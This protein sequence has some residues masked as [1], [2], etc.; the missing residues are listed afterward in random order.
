ML[1]A[2][3]MLAGCAQLRMIGVQ[4][5]LISV[6]ENLDKPAAEPPVLAAFGADPPVTTSQDW[7]Q[8]RAPLLRA[9]F[10]EHV[11]G[12]MPGPAPVTAVS[13][14][15]LSRDAYGG[16]A[17]V[18]ELTLRIGAAD[19]DS[20]WI[21]RLALVL[22]RKALDAG[23]SSPVIIAQNFCGN[24]VAVPGFGVAAPLTAY[25]EACESAFW[26]PIIALLFGAHN[27]RP[28]VEQIIARG[29]AYVS[30]YPGEIVP[31][32]RAAAEPALSKLAQLG[33][34]YGRPGAV[35]AWAWAYLRAA[36]Y[37]VTRDEIAADKI[38][39]WGHSRNG[40]SA[41]LAGVFDPRIAAVIA[42]QSGTGGATLNRNPAGETVAQITDG[43]GYWFGEAYADYA[44]RED[45]LPI[46]QHQLLA[47]LAPRPVFL[48]NAR[49][50]V[51]SGP[52]SSFRAA[53]G[54]QDAY[55]L[56]GAQGLRQIAMDPPDLN[57]DMAFFLRAGG[58]GVNSA[59][60][61]AFLAFL[62][63]H[64]PPDPAAIT[65]EKRAQDAQAG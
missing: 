4:T 58:H 43:Y 34:A 30:Q 8:R 7:T 65:R 45:A 62:D 2:A 13:R 36:D 53:L 57:A 33:A 31:D 55:A 11:Y 5:R 42:H 17:Q 26:R 59:D 23:A 49:R 51:W 27:G 3:S 39:V 41:L 1:L 54:A 64:T 38:S 22:P 48:G 56:L 52:N 61:D 44:D 21:M 20:G 9:A 18:E 37:L 19:D 6:S 50:D 28:P 15:V 12:T 63:T 40:K 60:W 32:S 35:G 47:L 14:E 16:L 29:Y 25:P 10:Q 46:D 24:H